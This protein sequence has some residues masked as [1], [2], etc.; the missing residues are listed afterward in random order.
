MELVGILYNDTRQAALD[1]RRQL[2]GSWPLVEDPGG[3]TTIDYGVFGVPETY[4]VDQGGV[5]RAKLLGA[6]RP[7]TLDDILAR[8][9]TDTSIYQKNDDYRTSPG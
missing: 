7:G 4:V 3:R 5:I 2:G 9:N 1:F 8:L 6:I